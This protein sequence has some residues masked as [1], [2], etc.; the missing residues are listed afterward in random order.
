[1]SLIREK[2]VLHPKVISITSNRKATS[3]DR[4]TSVKVINPDRVVISVRVATSAKV[5]TSPDRADTSDRVVTSR[6]I[7]S[8]TSSPRQPVSNRTLML[9][10]PQ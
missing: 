2:K 5:V 8:A 4:A 6:V 7:N 3:L 1:M 10:A 9:K